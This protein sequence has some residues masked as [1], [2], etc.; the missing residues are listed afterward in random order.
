[1]GGPKIDI[2]LLDSK[3]RRYQMATVQLDFQLPSKERFNLKC[4]DENGKP[5][6]IVMIHRAVLG[7]VERFVSI[8]LEHCNGRLPFWLSPRQVKIVAIHQGRENDAAVDEYAAEVRNALYDCDL[9]VDLA[10]VSKKKKWSAKYKKVLQ[11]KFSVFMFIGDKEM[12]SRSVSI[13][14]QKS[15]LGLHSLEKCLVWLKAVAEQKV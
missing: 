15:Q 4:I 11:E 5:E 8:L 7:S 14:V 10:V 13:R 9:F 3:G 12:K 6:R 1:M 2:S